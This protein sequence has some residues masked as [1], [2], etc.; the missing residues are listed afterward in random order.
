MSMLEEKI[1]QSVL[2][3]DELKAAKQLV[4]SINESR[5]II[6]R[7]ITALDKMIGNN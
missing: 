4:K 5:S 6:R 3:D 2:K 1:R 7:S